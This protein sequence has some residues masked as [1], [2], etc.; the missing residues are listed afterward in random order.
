LQ[1]D[2]GEFYIG[3]TNDLRLRLLEHGVGAGAQATVNKQGKP[4]WFSHTH[5]GESAKQLGEEARVS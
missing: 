4:A 2:A 1:L 5:D 3:Q